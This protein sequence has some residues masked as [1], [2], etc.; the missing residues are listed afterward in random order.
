MMN[1]GRRHEQGSGLIVVI[2]VVALLMGIG[3][4]LLTL[5]SMSP[6]VAGTMR[7]HEEAFNAAEAGFDAARLLIEE[8]MTN[9]SWSGFAGHYLTLPLGIDIPMI[10]GVPNPSYFRRLTDQEILQALDLN[11]DGTADVPNLLYFQQT[12]AVN[13]QGQTD[14]RYTYTVF[15]INNEAGGGLAN[16]TDALLVSIGTVRAG[17]RVLDS[18]RL[19]V[20]VTFE[21]E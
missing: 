13:G 1:R 3:I 16:N 18:V 6:K 7:Y 20:L 2:M 12:F 14:L 17:T 8:N 21:D 15:L 9:G 10:L 4:P 19:E 5:T 11:G